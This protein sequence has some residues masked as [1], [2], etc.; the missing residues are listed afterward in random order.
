M[1]SRDAVGSANELLAVSLRSDIQETLGTMTV[2][3]HGGSS[4]PFKPAALLLADGA[5]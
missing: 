4:S 3:Q 1:V 5:E 2:F